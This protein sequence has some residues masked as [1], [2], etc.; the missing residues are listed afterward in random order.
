M[1]RTSSLPGGVVNR[2][3]ELTTSLAGRGS[4]GGWLMIRAWCECDPGIGERDLTLGMQQ[5]NQR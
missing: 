1:R 2:F 3:D 4:A 5:R